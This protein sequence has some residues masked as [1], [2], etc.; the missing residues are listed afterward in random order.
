MMG[1][2]QLNKVTQ[3]DKGQHYLPLLIGHLAKGI[4][5]VRVTGSYTINQSLHLVKQ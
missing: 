4:Y 5:N 2:V 1:R 3:L